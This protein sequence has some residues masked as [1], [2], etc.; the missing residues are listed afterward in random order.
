MQNQSGRIIVV[1]PNDEKIEVSYYCDDKEVNSG[2]AKSFSNV[3][4]Q[5]DDCH[6]SIKISREKLSRRQLL[7]AAVERKVINSKGH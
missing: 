4:I 7:E 3:F 2:G 5:M 6:T 1:I